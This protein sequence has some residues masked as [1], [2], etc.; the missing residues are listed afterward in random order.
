[1]RDLRSGLDIV[2]LQR[3]RPRLPSAGIGPV[4]QGVARLFH[5]RGAGDAGK[6]PATLL[7]ELDGA[8]ENVIADGI[9]PRGAARS[10]DARAAVTALVGLRRALFPSA[11]AALAPVATGVPA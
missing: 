1:L 2:A 10:T 3:A 7:A 8:L 5:L 11:P 9:A 6:P 4:M